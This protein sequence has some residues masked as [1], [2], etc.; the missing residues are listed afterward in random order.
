MNQ[1]NQ[2]NR[3]RGKRLFLMLFPFMA[4][5]FLLSYLPLWGWVYAFF[6]YKPGLPIGRHNFVGWENFR[7]LAQDQYAVK[8]I[9]R[10]LRNT[11]A[12]SLIGMAT[13]W[14]PMA[15]AI[16]LNEI[17]HLRYRKIVQTLTTIPN[18]VSWVLVFSVAYSMFSVDDGFINRLLIRLGIISEGIPF[19]SSGK[20]VWLTMWLWGTWKGLGWSAIMYIAALMS[21]DQELYEAAK[22]DGAGRFACIWHI[23]IPSILPTYFVLLILSIASFLNSGM[24]QYLIFQN[25]MNRSWIEVLDLY[26]YNQGIAGINYSHSVAVGML[27][28]LVSITLLLLANRGSKLLREESIF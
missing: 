11:F 6:N 7:V 25:P 17:K 24:E 23:T 26:I 3:K 27:K 8:D 5:T 21:V 9:L 1:L 12:M 4:L 10:V 16:L 15:F 2:M 18:F 13:S 14:L 28:S 20:H 19:M 22:V